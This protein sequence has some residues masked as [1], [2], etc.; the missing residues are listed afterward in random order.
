[1]K[2]VARFDVSEYT[3]LNNVVRWFITL[4][5]IAVA[6]VFLVLVVAWIP[7]ASVLPL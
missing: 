6:G 7:Y 2:P 1:M 4:R 3:N 5:W